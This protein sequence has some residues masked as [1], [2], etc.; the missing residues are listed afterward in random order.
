MD[1]K[2]S[3]AKQRWERRRRERD[4]QNEKEEPPVLRLRIS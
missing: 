3:K 2:T 4:F 1:I